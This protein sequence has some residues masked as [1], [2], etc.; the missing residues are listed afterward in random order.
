MIISLFQDEA[1]QINGIIAV[2]DFSGIT[3]GHVGKID[4][5][6]MKLMV[7]FMQVSETWLMVN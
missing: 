1:T 4:K 7:S 6:Y 2:A 5:H 3:L